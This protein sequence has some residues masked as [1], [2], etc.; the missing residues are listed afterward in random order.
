MFIVCRAFVK[1]LISFPKPIVA[2]VNGAAVGFGAAFLPL[3]DLVY[4]SDKAYFECPNA[5]LNL[6]PE[7]CSSF[8]FKSRMG[9]AAVRCFFNSNNGLCIVHISI[10]AIFTQANDVLL[11]GRKFTASEALKMGFVSE[12]LWPE[13]QRMTEH[14]TRKLTR[15]TQASAKVSTALHC[16]LIATSNT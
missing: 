9:D 13:Q 7:A 3:C 2:L 16:A 1:L 5:Q 4:A 11:T 10:S 15:M 6:T 14:I 8:T 12:V